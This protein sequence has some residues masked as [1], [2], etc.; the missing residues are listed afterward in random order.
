MLNLEATQDPFEALVN[1]VKAIVNPGQNEKRSIEE[2]VRAGFAE[3]FANESSGNGDEWKPL[4]PKT[5]IDRRKRGFPT[6]HPILVRTGRYRASFTV[7]G[8]ANSLVEEESTGSEWTMY[9]G[10][11]DNR[12]ILEFG[13][14]TIIND[15][16]VYVPPRPA[17]ILS[18]QAES[19]IASV[20]ER[21]IAQIE[22]R[23][24]EA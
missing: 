4:A 20:I 17:T 8:S 2:A 13:G 1:F 23:T 9:V 22:D 6:Q 16:E 5:N 11:S 19:N 3:N 14:I 12:R 21:V 15:H 24:L 7:P 18:D 10:S